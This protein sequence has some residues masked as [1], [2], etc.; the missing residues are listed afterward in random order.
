M[1][2]VPSD[3]E[4]AKVVISSEVVYKNVNPTIVRHDD[5]GRPQAHA[6]QALRLTDPARPRAPPRLRSAGSPPAPARPT[7]ATNAERD[8][9]EPRCPAEIGVAV[10][11]APSSGRG[12]AGP[13]EGGR[14]TAPSAAPSRGAGRPGAATSR[15]ASGPGGSGRR[16]PPPPRRTPSPAR[17]LGAPP[18]T[19]TT[20]TWTTTSANAPQPEGRRSAHSVARSSAP[21]ANGTKPGERSRPRGGPRGRHRGRRRPPRERQ[22]RLRIIAPTTLGARD[23]RVAWRST[24]SSEPGPRQARTGTP[25]SAQRCASRSRSSS[26]SRQTSRASRAS[27]TPVAARSASSVASGP[28]SSGGQG[29]DDDDGVAAAG[30]AHGVGERLGRDQRRQ[31]DDEGPRR[32]G[33]GRAGRAAPAPRRGCPGWARHDRARGA[34]GRAG[35]G[36]RR[37][38]P[39]RPRHRRAP[40]GPTRSPVV[41]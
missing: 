3:D 34:P 12:D 15:A 9:T 36:R 33:C 30:E 19:A 28:A 5:D 26:R 23:R 22:V 4:I 13:D 2:D 1:F 6:A 14:V 29:V 8:R 25:A 38:A 7:P 11:S 39:R 35:G 27:S 31:Q 40:T 41:R 37:P 16:R 18:G 10:A 21:R 32:D 20:S 24:V 17:E